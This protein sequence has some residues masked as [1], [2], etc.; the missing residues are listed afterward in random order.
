MLLSLACVA[1]LLFFI[2]HISEAI[3]VNHIVDRIA[4]ETEDIIDQTMPNP[5]RHDRLTEADKHADGQMEPSGREA[6]VLSAVSGYV[7]FIDVRRLT[8]PSR[9]RR[10]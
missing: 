8:F 2:H 1:W 9:G 4:K 6:P 7:R 5:V 3:S 10:A